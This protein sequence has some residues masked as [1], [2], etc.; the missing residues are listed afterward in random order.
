MDLAAKTQ[1]AERLAGAVCLLAVA[2]SALYFA[3]D[4]HQTQLVTRQAV[5][6]VSD[7]GKSLNQTLIAVNRPCGGPQPCGTLAEINRSA[8]KLQD[9][10]VTLQQQVMQS[11]QLVNAA[12]QSLTSV[13]AHL[14][15]TADALTGTASAATQT[16]QQART[17]LQTANGSIAALRPLL[18]SSQATVEDMDAFIKDAALQR[19]K[20]NLA[21]TAAHLSTITGN[22]AV[23]STKLTNDFMA[24]KPWW[25]KI[26]SEMGDGL[27]LVGAGFSI[28]H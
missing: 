16:L 3:Y 17:D 11:S 19:L 13:S 22:A 20:E 6:Q 24:K 14:N 5:E 1:I 27:K 8:V 9:I 18:A 21:E 15:Q 28:A 25:K 7:V 26:G 23:V 4:S 12:S 10:T 2:G